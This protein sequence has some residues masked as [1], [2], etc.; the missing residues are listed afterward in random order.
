MGLFISLE[1]GEAVGKTI[2]SKI[3]RDRLK[4]LSLHWELIHEPG[5]TPLGRQLR[6]IVKT[7]RMTFE[8]ELLLFS[9]ARAELVSRVIKPAL[10]E[11]IVLIADRFVDSTTA[12]QGYGRGVSLKWVKSINEISTRGIMPEL[13]I[14]LD[15][16]PDKALQRRASQL[17]FTSDLSIDED[18][19]KDPGGESK[20]EEESIS[21]HKRVRDGYLKLARKEPERWLV[22]DASQPVEAVAKIIWMR[23][24]SL[25]PLLSQQSS[26]YK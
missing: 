2:Q 20:F 17:T 26:R 9:A 22:V 23:V 13:T 1:G 8:A 14:L 6:P 19:R 25:L 21:F 12:Y 24:H 4:E 11:E 7:S 18:V 10:S 3:L 16:P 15:M 5:D